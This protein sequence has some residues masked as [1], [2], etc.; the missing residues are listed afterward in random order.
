MSA[1]LAVA[2]APAA[3]IAEAHAQVTAP[4]FVTHEQ[5]PSA[6]PLPD[7]TV[8]A[9]S[10][11]APPTQVPSLAYLQPG[12]ETTQPVVTAQVDQIDDEASMRSTPRPARRRNRDAAPSEP[13]VFIETLPAPATSATP[14]EDE[15]PRRRTPRTRGARPVA[16]EPL[17][18]VETKNVNANET[19]GEGK[20]AV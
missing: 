17:Q 12:I 20:G 16:S 4:H 18:F 1:P 6:V 3:P 13:L 9:V 10:I 11:P 2:I 14:V 5:A 15:A 19:D 8:A 7:Q